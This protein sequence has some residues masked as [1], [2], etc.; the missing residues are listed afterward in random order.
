MLK[1]KKHE[2]VPEIIIQLLQILKIKIIDEVVD[3]T[4]QSHPDYPSF[5]SINNLPQLLQERAT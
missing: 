1:L 2:Q 5:L 3:E 4:L